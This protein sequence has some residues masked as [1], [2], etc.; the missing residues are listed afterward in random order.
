MPINF[1]DPLGVDFA[2]VID[3]DR[4]LSLVDGRLCLAQALV[5]R[6]IMPLGGLF[7]DTGYGLGL[8]GSVGSSATTFGGEQAAAESECLK[9]ER[10]EQ[11][12]ANI[13]Y[14]AATQKLSVHIALTTSDEDEF[15]LTFA[16]ADKLSEVI[17]SEF[18]VTDRIF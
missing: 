15:E 3:L 1:D 13:F 9:D 10:I 12:A 11:A 14:S 5:R 18:S 2:G 6:L 7:Y 16:L 8:I 4:R 17:V